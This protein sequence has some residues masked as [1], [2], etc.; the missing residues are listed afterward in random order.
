[1][2]RIAKLFVSIALGAGVLTAVTA[3]VATV[4]TTA[5]IVHPACDPEWQSTPC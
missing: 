2:T 3:D 4:Q 1:M 5:M